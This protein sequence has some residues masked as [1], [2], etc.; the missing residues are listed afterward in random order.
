MATPIIPKLA[1][2]SLQD[3]SNQRGL[4]FEKRRPS[5]EVLLDALSD[6]VAVQGIKAF[7]QILKLSD[8][9][10][11]TTKMPEKDNW[12]KTKVV[13]TKRLFE[14][15]QKD[16]ITKFLTSLKPSEQLLK[17][18]LERLG[19]DQPTASAKKELIDLIQTEIHYL[20]L[21]TIFSNCSVKQLKKYITDLDLT[22]ESSAKTVLLRC[23]L[24][25]TDYKAEDKPK[26]VRKPRAPKQ[27]ADGDTEMS[28]ESYEFNPCKPFKGE[29]WWSSDDE[30]DGDFNTDAVEP[31]D[32]TDEDM[33]EVA[34]EKEEDEEEDEE[35]EADDLDS[36]YKQKK[37]KKGAKVEEAEAD[38]ID[39]DEDEDAGDDDAE[40]TP[41]RKYGTRSKGSKKQKDE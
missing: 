12:T 22:V 41:Q 15:M 28:A 35:K 4:T 9:E 29:Y 27:D 33:T 23:L 13:L 19:V 18:V 6:D 38:D 1:Q 17:T 24:T 20:G 34:S 5:K 3:I 30:E 21:S 2:S 26:I 37:A 11:L 31:K 8:L 32:R 7:V 14:A 10:A 16:G 39:E 36:E 25:M 40:A